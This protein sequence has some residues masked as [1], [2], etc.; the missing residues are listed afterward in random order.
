MDFFTIEKIKAFVDSFLT[1]TSMGK[2][3]LTAFLISF[4]MLSA[5]AQ[6]TVVGSNTNTGSTNSI[7]VT[8]P[9]GLQV[10]D[11]MIVNLMIADNGTINTPSGWSGVTGLNPWEAGSGST[12]AYLW[13]KVA[14][15][16]DV[17]ASNFTFTTLNEQQAIG[18]SAY[19]G[20]NTTTNGG[21]NVIGTPFESNTNVATITPPSITTTSANSMVLFF[22][23]VRL[24][25]LAFNANWKLGGASGT[26][27]NQVY[28][29]NAPNV[30]DGCGVSAGWFNQASA[31]ASG[32]GYQ[33]TVTN[34]SGRRSGVLVA[35]TPVPAVTTLGSNTVTA[36]SHCNGAT[37]VPIQS[38]T[39]SQ[40]IN[41]ANLT[42]VNFTT[43]GSYIASDLVRFQ[44]W[45]NTTNNLAGATQIG[46]NITT[47]LGAGTH[48]FSSLSQALTI[49]QQRFFWI[50]ADLTTAAAAAGQSTLA[51]NA[52]GSSNFTVSLGGVS[53]S[54]TAGGNQTMFV[55][56]TVNK[57]DATIINGFDGSITVTS[58]NGGSGTYQ[59]RLDAGAWQSSN[60]FTGLSAGTYSVQIRDANNTSCASILGNT[61]INEPACLS[62]PVSDTLIA[63]ADSE[64]WTTQPNENYG[65][66]DI[67]YLRGSSPT[68]RGVFQFNLAS[69]PANA[70]VTSASLRLVKIGGST[71]SSNLTV[72]RITS[73]WTEGTGGCNVPSN[74]TSNVTW[75]NRTTGTPWDAAGGDFIA[76]PEATTA[77]GANQAYT[78]NIT[79]LAQG[80]VANTFSNN[81]VLLRFNNDVGTVLF[82]IASR[83]NGT[84][85][86]HPRLFITYEIP[87]NV[88]A[89]VNKV[90][91]NCFGASNGQI[92]VTSPSGGS[93]TYQY[94]LNTGSWQ[95][96]NSFTNLA[97]G[98]YSVQIRDAN[99]FA[100]AFFLD[101][102]TIIQPAVLNASGVTVGV[103]CAGASNGS[104][105]QNVTGGTANYTYVW[106]DGPAI[107]KDRNGLAGGSYQVTISDTNNC[108]IVRNY[109]VSEP[110]AL[111]VDTVVTQPTC[112]TSG[113]I[114]LNVSGG[115]GPYTYNWSDLAGNNN[116]KDRSGLSAG[117]FSVTVTDSRSCTQ[118]LSVTLNDPDC[119]PGII[120]CTNDPASV[121]TTT[122]DPF[123]TSYFW[124]VPAGAFITSGQGTSSITID[125]SGATPGLG[126]ICVSAL[127]TCGESDEFCEGVIIRQI[128]PSIS[129][130]PVCTGQNIQ[131]F[132]GGG[133]S[134]QWSGPNG[135]T[136]SLQNPFIFNATPTNNGTYTVTI[137]EQGCSI[138]TSVTLNINNAPTATATTTTPSACGQAIGEIEVDVTGGTGP[139]GFLW[140]TGATTQNIGSLLGGNYFVTVTDASGCVAQA[141]AS[142]P[143]IDGPALTPSVTNILCNG[144]TTGSITLG[145]SGGT[146]PITYFWSNGATTQNI[147]NLSVGTYSVIATDNFGC[148]GA[149]FGNVTQ[150]NPLQLD[151][152][153][154]NVNCF[155]ESTGTINLSVSGGTPGYTVTWSD[156]P[157]TSFARTGLTAG[158]YT[159]YVSDVNSCI[160]SITLVISQPAAALDATANKTDIACNGGTNG[161]IDLTVT[162]GTAP[163]TY[164]W[165][166]SAT[167]QDLS[168]LAAGTYTVTIT[169]SR[170]CVLSDV[171]ATI[172][173]PAA[174]TAGAIPTAVNCF[175]EAT[176]SVN[177]TVS[178]GTAP[179]TY[180]WS[181][182]S[183]TE[184]ISNLLAGTYNV[185]VTDARGCSFGTFATVSEP[186]LGLSVSADKSDNL[187]FNQSIGSID[188][189]VSGGTLNY[190][191]AWSDGPS[192][193]QNRTDLAAGLYTA[194]VTDNNSC[195]AQVQVNITQPD[196]INVNTFA[197][198][199]SCNGD[200]DGAIVL[201]VSGGTGA[202]SYSWTGGLPATKDQENLQAGSYTVTVADANSCSTQRTVTVNQPAALTLNGVAEDANCNSANDGA[203]DISV[204]GGVAPYAY[205]WSNNQITE[206]ITD[207]APGVYTFTVTDLNAC[208]IIDSFEIAEPTALVVTSD[209]TPN[210]LAQSNGSVE[211]FVSGGTAPYQ[212]DWT[213]GG[214]GSNPRTG[215]SA[216]V[217]S[218][219][220]SDDNGCE[221]DTSFELIPLELS[222][223]EVEITCFAPGEVFAVPSGG[224]LPYTYGWNTGPTTQSI[225]GLTPGFYEVTVTSGA[226][227]LTESV[228]LLAPICLPPVAVDD[229]DT[230]LINIPVTGTVAPPNP[231]DPGYDSDPFYP[232][233]SL[234]IYPLTFI[235]PE[236]GVIEWDTSFNGTYTFIPALN[237][238]GTVSVI[239]TICNPLGLCDD[240]VL[241][242]T[243]YV[244]N[245]TV[246]LNDENSTF[247]GIPASGN[248]TTNDF[249]IEG[250]NQIFGSFINEQGDPISSGDPIGGVD[251]DGN[252]VANAGE[253]VFDASGNYTYT[254]A[255]GFTGVAR[256]PYSICDDGIP[257][258][259]DSA[260]LEITVSPFPYNA[261]SVIA[262]NDEYTSLGEPVTGD[263]L[264]ND[265]DPQGDNFD[266]TGYEYDSNG[267]GVP[268]ATGTLGS[269]ASV[270]GVN[271]DGTPNDTVGVLTLNSDGTFE[272]VPVPGFFGEVPLIYTIC[273]DG[274][275]QACDEATIVIAVIPDA[276]GPENNPPVAG[277]DFAYTNINTPVN[278]TFSGNDYDLNGDSI[279]VNGTPIDING[280]TTSIVVLNTVEGGT[281]ELFT[282]GSFI[283]TP[284]IGFTGPDRVEYEICDIT[285]VEPQPLCASAMI[286]LLVGVANTTYAVND[287]NSTWANKPASGDVT[288]NDFD[289][290][291]HNQTF[292]SFLNPSTFAPITSGS[293]V[294]GVNLNGDPVANAGVLTFG[295]GGTYTY[296][297][298]IGFTGVVSVPYSICDDG[299]PEVCDTAYLTITVSPVILTTN[300]LI[301]NNDEYV[302]FSS[303]E[304][305]LFINDADPQGD[306]FE[307]TTYLYDSN[308]DG[309]PDATGNLN[310]VQTVGGVDQAGNTVASA[311]TLTLNDDG[312]FSF[313]AIGGFIGEVTLQYN[314]C[315]DGTPTACATANVTITVL[316]DPNGPAN[317]P[318]VAGDD[319]VFT[320]YNTP[321][322]G[323]YIGND[324]DLNGDSLSFNGITI[325][326]SGPATPIT[327][328]ATEEGGEVIIYSDGTFLYTPADGFSGSDRVVYEI[329]DVTDVEPQPLC[330][331][332]TIHMLVAIPNTTYAVNDENSTWQEVPAGGNVLTN[333]FDLEGHTQT[334]GSFLNPT[335]TGDITSGA[336]V[337][338]IDTD[339]NPVANAG[340]LTFDA[341]GNYTY[342]PAPGFTGTMSVPYRLCD[343]GTPIACDTAVLEISVRS[344]TTLENSII[345]N[346][347]EYFTLGDPIVGDV[348]V[349]DAD[350][351][352]DNFTIT[353][354]SYDSNGD[355][356]PNATGSLNGAQ[357]VAGF[358]FFGNPVANAGVLTLNANGTFNFV[359][360]DSFSGIV[361]LTYT[362]CD[363]GTP[364]ACD[365][366]N[367]LIGVLVDQN[368]PPGG[369]GPS[370]DPPIAGDD[371]SYT[372]INAAVDGSFASNDYDLNGD[373][374]S[375]NGITIVPNGPRTP[376][377]TL[378]TL[379]GGTVI[380]FADGTYSYFPPLNYTGPDRVIYEI[381]D[382][383][384]ILPQPL[385][386]QAT[387]HMLIGDGIT[388]NGLVWQDPDGSITI[389]NGEQ[390]TNANTDLYINVVDGF[391]RV[392][393]VTKV[394]ADGTYSLDSVP[395][396]TNLAL[397]LSLTQGVVGQ[398]APAPSLPAAWANTGQ[399][400]DGD[401]IRGSP[402]V[403]PF[404]SGVATLENLDF[405]IELRP[406]AEEFIVNTVYY[407]NVEPTI[408]NPLEVLAEYFI[409]DDVDGTVD[410]IRLI[411]FPTNVLSITVNSVTYTASN[412]PVG[413]I[414]LPADNNGQPVGSI[415]VVPD[416]PTHSTV[417]IPFVPI[418]NAGVEGN[419]A[420]ITITFSTILPVELVSFE[421][422]KN[423]CVVDLTWLTAT[424]FNNDF[425]TVYRSVDA[426]NWVSIGQVKGNGSTPFPSNY[427]FTDESPIAGL[428]Y[429]RLQQ[430]DYDGTTEWLPIRSV[431]MSDCGMASVRIYP[432]PTSNIINIELTDVRPVDAY[433]AIY[434][435]AG[436]LMM[437]DH[438]TG[439]NLHKIDVSKLAGGSY[440]LSI[441]TE[442]ATKTFKVVIVR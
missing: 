382:V 398:A 35:L 420:N 1:R 439:T 183:T 184:D 202:Y 416:Y 342:T 142:V 129:T 371:F 259:C 260:V 6:I 286:H 273:D 277:D 332:A 10:G 289:I 211:L 361:N 216:G 132:A 306:A 241:T 295:A 365:D 124:T 291:G 14:N 49:G 98:G 170:G 437:T 181:N 253:L 39:L 384:V 71:T 388:I 415:A 433:L 25:N 210:C 95:S 220:I 40:T 233:D 387:I 300:S 5:E 228:T 302:T 418:D 50:T 206:D 118:N 66:C 411:V 30:S 322:T 320:Y 7:T 349:N 275:P 68:E 97:A 225:S 270:A 358:D 266:V 46:S 391:G 304:G 13:Y 214:N 76:T 406:T 56:A 43:T 159:A 347:D 195:T 48:T 357:Q 224:L 81:G 256:V 321:V 75:N 390:G 329:C 119:G 421:A 397:V 67:I 230:T 405:G 379:Q 175:G 308:G 245:R 392:V 404:F 188:L 173:E 201:V 36:A 191:Y 333:D 171:S 427:S 362:I 326:I 364:V 112:A 101:S 107:T 157:S 434:N 11:L 292:G 338:G 227:S 242:I 151:G 419:L 352:G 87:N 102:V 91:V 232:L 376:V 317:D 38:F 164:L 24:Q 257:V 59:F 185:T 334:F 401:I 116:P 197:T 121:Y 54:S 78:W 314:I 149:A 111:V 297:P 389:N 69:I 144:G 290:E 127:N 134:Y 133:S 394:N 213:G 33:T 368:G 163:Y 327:T 199:I 187:C 339:G 89:I 19:R 215:L 16:T 231:S 402:G 374:I 99:D 377:D 150:P 32:T 207:L 279:S 114:V 93:G 417:I 217:V 148:V 287:E 400:F 176:G 435:A 203:I 436:A 423:G 303:V 243:V 223:L 264:L 252:P 378:T 265:D 131:L 126:E 422:V 337:S 442:D 209:I 426:Q 100:C 310:G 106:N 393:G 73:A 298:A 380:L 37:K 12:R 21:I 428:T 319:F 146:P 3:L 288:T 325:N 189:T 143:D 96:S 282:D 92:N 370:N 383:T 20:V 311:G 355:G 341:S 113:S 18:I 53:G 52:M 125:W 167:T 84:S 179:Y 29:R 154:T 65:A 182:N 166:N 407:V 178:G 63:T 381:C 240:A 330:A 138:D 198:D 269:P 343:D 28:I 161:Q 346:N 440:M 234:E 408:Q 152:T 413:G 103:T 194:T 236:F 128:S 430:T 272:F 323:N 280:P 31:G 276:N 263:V 222:L 83:Q 147:S 22:S 424:E 204:G 412:F 360:A 130:S 372:S 438:I 258:A 328:L 410:S 247:E 237:F 15:S 172:N 250:D 55:G 331:S 136:S 64:I 429:Y 162:G 403:L 395:A 51:V 218:V 86:N 140:S 212:F 283:F 305:D 156:G 72:H 135:F 318:P 153:K 356:I 235:D 169:D 160:D 281:V 62:T 42:S 373:P 141:G 61:V 284:P 244:E 307:V 165:S 299:Y 45:T 431:D 27:M 26:D 158:T 226:C 17:A 254:P 351:Q 348:F 246:A 316:G 399:N 85:A 262:N 82:N 88:T 261:N 174:L 344:L 324:Y 155:G 367:I 9:A 425:F 386:A 285:D 293:Q 77:V 268:D 369:G 248:V 90:D 57:T 315:D 359:P 2:G 117:T 74:N 139:F 123:V 115:T 274:T 109:T 205:S 221:V 409:T 340:T 353:T 296:T 80:W 108:S 255:P 219:I 8:K 251:S 200:E 312:T 177:L 190:T 267:D 354:Y 47:N 168:G 58:P 396:S 366:A 23:Q 94:R 110:A 350:P 238:V 249:D 192:T 432:N 375:V 79:S 336:P 335:S 60:T 294:S 44:L 180:F 363:D 229:F 414:T 120:V 239:Y 345:A 309:T 271:R 301:A 70:V 104:I 385:C 278:G 186:A 122:P 193:A 105:T 208:A 196:S 145:V 34:T 441:Q 41:A 313:E 4:A 137:E